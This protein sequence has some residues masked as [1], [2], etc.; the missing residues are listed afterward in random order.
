MVANLL[1]VPQSHASPP[2]ILLFG[3]AEREEIADKRKWRIGVKER[4][5][6]ARVYTMLYRLG[7]PNLYT[8]LYRSTCTPCCTGVFHTTTKVTTGDLPHRHSTVIMSLI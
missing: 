4:E 6:G 8:V 3:R 5:K 2:T 1:C 7:P